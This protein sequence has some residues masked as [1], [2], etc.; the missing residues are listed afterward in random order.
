MTWITS[1]SLAAHG[2][3]LVWVSDQGSAYG[4][5]MSLTSSS[6]S[7]CSTPTVTSR[8]SNV[9]ESGIAKSYLKFAKARICGSHSAPA[10]SS[11]SSS[12]Q[13]L[14][15]QVHGT[16]ADQHDGNSEVQKLS[17]PA[18]GALF[19]KKLKHAMASTK[20]VQQS[21][22]IISD[23]S[24]DVMHMQDYKDE[25][26]QTCQYL[27]LTAKWE[28]SVTM[29]VK[30]QL[31]NFNTRKG[32]CTY[33]PAHE[34]LWITKK[35]DDD[36]NVLVGCRVCARYVEDSDRHDWRCPWSGCAIP[37][38]EL[39]LHRVQKHASSKRHG[40]ALQNFLGDDE[41]KGPTG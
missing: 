13:S 9:I 20:R 5:S 25:K 31:K 24:R 30:K 36:G 32:I 28:R 10:T 23:D 40:N 21:L 22:A 11:Q 34:S 14:M 7:R 12:R 2:L 3:L 41:T 39:A 6:A 38:S 37:L 29:D 16:E 26:C 15:D 35:K 1:T 27:A 19:M 18:A 17:S 8:A 4:G 33:L